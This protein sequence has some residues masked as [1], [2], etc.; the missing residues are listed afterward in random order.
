MR[1]GLYPIV[2]VL[3]IFQVGRKTV[4][5]RCKGTMK[6]G[7]PTYKDLPKRLHSIGLPEGCE[8]FGLNIIKGVF[9]QIICRHNIQGIV[10]LPSSY[11]VLFLRYWEKNNKVNCPRLA[12]AKHIE[13]QR[14]VWMDLRCKTLY[15][16][17]ET[18]SSNSYCGTSYQ[19]HTQTH[20]DRMG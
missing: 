6:V 11:K 1:Q 8:L 13:T 10:G 2:E 19:Q 17:R 14:P 15:T 12:Y 5:I 9:K 20:Q 3:E 7:R 18:R 4:R 16:S